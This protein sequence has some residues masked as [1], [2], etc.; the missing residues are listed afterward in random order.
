MDRSNSRSARL[1]KRLTGLSLVAAALGVL[2]LGSPE[3]SGRPTTIR[4]GVKTNV[5]LTQELVDALGEYGQVGHRMW[6]LDT[7]DMRIDEGDLDELENLGFVQYVEADQQVVVYGATEVSET[8][9]SGGDRRGHQRMG[10]C[11]G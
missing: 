9:F 8:D 5:A 10:Q 11:P 2:A 3:A 1:G 7:V 4:V 6:S